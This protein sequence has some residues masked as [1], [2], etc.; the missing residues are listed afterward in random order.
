MTT[1]AY[2]RQLRRLN[3]VILNHADEYEHLMDMATSITAPT[4]SDKV[5]SGSSDRLGNTV[6]KMVD[7]KKDLARMI[8]ERDKIVYQLEH[9]TDVTSYTILF[10][11]YGLDESFMELAREL[12]FSKTHICRLYHKALDQFEREYGMTYLTK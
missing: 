7:Y 1:D 8:T 6:A 3:A 10:R 12:H 9:M 11:Y 4:D 5:S 2:L